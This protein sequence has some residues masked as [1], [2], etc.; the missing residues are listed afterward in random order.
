LLIT[1]WGFSGPAVLKLSAFAA[2]ILALMQ[3]QFSVSINWLGS[4]NENSLLAKLKTTRQELAPQKII[5]RNPFNIP[6]RL[7]QY[8][9]ELCNI[10]ESLRWAD[11][12]A[13]QQNLLAKQLTGQQFQVMGKTTFRDEF[14][15]AGGIVLQEVTP[16]TMMSRIVPDLFFAGEIMD[17]DGITGGFNFQH[18]WTSGYLAAA[19]VSRR[20]NGLSKEQG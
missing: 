13:K 19:E 7:W 5:R 14:V 6:Q 10:N 2:K 4:Y 9:V 12:P 17:V 8:H 15:T 11:L 1:H 16:G 3:Y 20:A 18:A